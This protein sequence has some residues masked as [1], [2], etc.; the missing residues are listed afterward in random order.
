MES[1]SAQNIC[2]QDVAGNI[3]AYLGVQGVVPNAAVGLSIFGNGRESISIRSNPDMTSEISFCG[4]NG[5]P[6]LRLL[7][8]VNGIVTAIGNI[9]AAKNS[10]CQP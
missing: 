6:S 9:I 8:D 5:N 10:V 2:I 1:I 4:A 3:V 7:V